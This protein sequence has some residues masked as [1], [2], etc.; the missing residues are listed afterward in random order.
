MELRQLE[1]LRLILSTGSFTAAAKRLGVSQPAISLHIKSLEEEF[2][3]RLLERDGK[4]VRTTP[5]G[6][7][8]LAAADAAFAALEDGARRIQELAAPDRGRLVLACGDTVALQW[9][10]PA[11]R[12][13]RSAW[14]RA[15]VAI[16]NHGSQEILRLVLEREADL[17]IATRPPWIDRALWSKTLGEDPFYVA[18]PPGHRLVGDAMPDLE[19][20]AAHDAVLLARPAETRAIVDRGFAARGLAVRCAMESGNLEVVKRYVA[21]GLGW[22]LL[23]AMSIA[24]GDRQRLVLREVPPA[25]FPPRRIVVVRRR[26]RRVGPLAAAFLEAL[27]ATLLPHA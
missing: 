24:E 2:G 9:L 22:S 26:D 11:L 13:F 12:A 23:P 19:A 10:P 16:R 8:L 14:P 1:S 25:V 7:A 20:L 15:E 21:D 27:A 6:A 17:G 4:G 18:L 5:A 3:A